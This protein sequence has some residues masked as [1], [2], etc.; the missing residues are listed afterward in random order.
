MREQAA[1]PQL[2]RKVNRVARGRSKK[3]KL[4]INLIQTSENAYTALQVIVVLSTT[5]FSNAQRVR[6]LATTL[7]TWKNPTLRSAAGAQ[8]SGVAGPMAFNPSKLTIAGK[9][10][11][12][13]E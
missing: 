8:R 10:Q 1:D 11:K 7:E 4:T 12:V 5:D 2:N 6:T 3:G 9:E 13:S